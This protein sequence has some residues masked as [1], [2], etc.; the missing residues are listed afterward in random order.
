MKKLNYLITGGAGYVGSELTELLLKNGHS[1]KIVDTFY[2]ETEIEENKNLIICKKDVR[3]LEISDFKD[4]DIV[5]DLASISNDPSGELNPYLTYKIN[6]E[7]RGKTATLAKKSGVKGYILASSC[8]VYGFNDNVVDENSPTN[9]LTTYAYA[10]LLAEKL[11]RSLSDSKFKVIIFRQATLFGSSKRMRTDLV[12][13]G[14]TYSGLE[15]RKINILRNGEQKRPIVSL[16]ELNS[17]FVTIN[18]AQFR[19]HSNEI[20]NIGNNNLNLEINSIYDIVNSVL[21]GNLEK[22]WYGEPDHRSYEVNFTKA[23]NLLPRIEK[24]NI[25]NEISN[26]MKR[27]GEESFDYEKSNTLGWYKSLLNLNPNILH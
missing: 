13:N 10:N 17:R 21:G 6:G 16:S 25:E 11:V 4:I 26:I 8:S 27:F 24:T 1:V 18:E 20:F 19:K 12:V 22:N 7:T 3:N 15:N 9:P 14:M 23:E 2:F 5:I